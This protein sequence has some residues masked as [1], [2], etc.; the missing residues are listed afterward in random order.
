[1]K[2]IVLGFSIVANLLKTKLE[3]IRASFENEDI[4]ALEALVLMP[5]NFLS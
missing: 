1:M 3:D 4:T 5:H 2:P